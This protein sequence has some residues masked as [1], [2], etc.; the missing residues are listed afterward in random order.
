MPEIKNNFLQGKMNQDLDER[1]IPN[2]QYREAMNVEVST[3]E[4]AGAGT[5]QN[6]LGNT[7]ASG[8][9]AMF[10]SCVCVG[11][12]ADEK[13][14]KLYWFVHC[15]DRDA[16]IEYDEI[17]DKSQ[18]ILCDL[19]SDE[20]PL[21]QPFLKFGSSKITGI[22]IID[23]FLFWTDGNSEP[24]K[25]NIK[26]AKARQKLLGDGQTISHH[27][28]YWTNTDGYAMPD[29]PYVREE[30]LTII[31]KKPLVAPKVKI[32]FSSTLKTSS[33]RIFERSFIRFCVR[34]KYADGEYSAYSP[35]TQVVYNPI[36]KSGLNNFNY[37]S[38]EESYNTSMIN[39]IESIDLYGF[40]DS[41]VN[42]DVVQVDVLAKIE[43]SPNVYSIK[44]IKR[45]DAE[46]EDGGELFQEFIGTA[47]SSYGGSL[48]KGKF[49]VKSESIHA[50]VPNNQNLRPW[51][52]VPRKALAQEVTGNRVVYGNYT[53][54]YSLKDVLNSDIN[55]G[56]AAKAEQR[57][58]SFEFTD[59]PTINRGKRS[60]KSQRSYTLGVVY[61]DVYGRETPVLTSDNA[62]V[63][64]PWY[65]SS[66]SSAL[67]LA[68]VPTMLS[69]EVSSNHPFWADSY[70]FYVKETSGEYY[71][72][73]M[74][75][76]YLPGS[77]DLWDN[78]DR[79][80]WIAFSSSDRNKVSE[81]TYL[82]IKKVLNPANYDQVTV[83]NKYKVLDIANEAPDAIKFDY[84]NLGKVSNN[85][86]ELDGTG[87]DEDDDNPVS[88]FPNQ[89][90][91]ID[92]E[93]DKI[94]ISKTD[95]NNISGSPF[96][97][98]VG[99]EDVVVEPDDIYISWKGLVSDELRN[100]TRYKVISISLSSETYDIKLATKISSIDAEI[101]DAA[102]A[103]A[104][105]SSL[106]FRVE[107]KAE[108]DGE[109]F[110]GKFFVK[111]QQDA[112]TSLN[113]AIG[114]NGDEDD[115]Q[116][117]GTAEVY[118]A[119]A[120][121]TYYFAN[122]SAPSYHDS[123]IL[124][125]TSD[126]IVPTDNPADVHG[127]DNI[128]LTVDDWDAL[129]TQDGTGVG[130]FFIDRTSF[131]SSAFDSTGLARESGQPFG[132]AEGQSSSTFHSSV[133]SKE[134]VWDPTQDA[135]ARV[136]G[137]FMDGSIADFASVFSSTAIG[138]FA[139]VDGNAEDLVNTDGAI[140]GGGPLE[141]FN[142]LLPLQF[143]YIINNIE[144][145][146]VGSIEQLS[147][148]FGAEGIED[149][150]DLF[151]PE[152][153]TEK[154]LDNVQKCY[155][156][157]TTYKGIEPN[158]LW[159]R[160]A[161]D[162]DGN[163][164]TGLEGIVESGS[165][166]TAGRYRWKDNPYVI[167][168]F[169]NVYEENG[170]Y[171]MYLSFL[172]PG[173]D[174]HDGSGLEAALQDN[175]ELNG[176]NGIGKY[177]Q[178]IW[179]GGVFS[180]STR[181][182]YDAKYEEVLNGI[183]PSDLDYSESTL[184]Q[185][186][187]SSV[188][189]QTNDYSNE[190]YT[191]VA[192]ETKLKHSRIFPTEFGEPVELSKFLTSN[193]SSQRRRKMHV[194]FEGNYNELNEPN[195]EPP[196]A[197]NAGDGVIGY[198]DN[199]ASRHYN[200]WNPAFGHPNET[201]INTFLFYLNQPNAQFRFANDTSE[202]V[203]TINSVT[204]K[205]LYNHTPWRRRFVLSKDAPEW[206]PA[207]D[208]VE[209][210]VIEW[211]NTCGTG[212]VPS[213][214]DGTASTLAER[215]IN[216]GK[217]SNRRLVYI[218]ELD[219]NPLTNLD[220]N[221]LN[222]IDADSPT[223]IEF[224]SANGAQ[225]LNT[226]LATFPA[227]METESKPSADLELYYEASDSIP[228]SINTKKQGE[229]FAPIGC[230]VEFPNM[231]FAST[232]NSSV[233]LA[234][235]SNEGEF[236]VRV[237]DEDV[238]GFNWFNPTIPTEM[239][240]YSGQEVRFIR[241]DGSYTTGIISLDYHSSL[242][243]DEFGTLN[244]DGVAFS[245]IE[246]DAYPNGI[247]N[248]FRI[249]ELPG[250]VGL[251]WYNCFTFEDGVESNR[252]R[253]D[254]NEMQITNGAKASTVIE[255]PYTEEHRKN[256]LIYSGIYNSNSGVNNLNQFIAAEKITK[257][258]NPT[259]GSIQ[260][261]YSR[262]TDLVALCED[263]IIKI[264]ANKD[265]LF[266]ADGTPQLVAT[267]NVLGQAVPFVGDY[268]ISKNPESFAS[269]SYRAYF[270]D[271]QR[272]AV[273][274]LS[275]DG[276][277]PISDAG[278]HDWF[279]DKFHEGQ[280]SFIGSYDN[281]KRQYNLTVSEKYFGNLISNG[282][283]DSGSSL[284]EYFVNQNIVENPSFAGGITEVFP[285]FQN[286]IYGIA[287]LEDPIIDNMFFNTPVVIRYHDEIPA[288]S[289]FEGGTITTPPSN[290]AVAEFVTPEVLPL[291]AQAVNMLDGSYGTFL[292]FEFLEQ[293]LD[294]IEAYGSANY[295]NN[296]YDTLTTNPISS[297]GSFKLSRTIAGNH[298]TTPNDWEDA[299]AAIG[300]PNYATNILTP[301]TNQY[302]GALGRAN[303]WIDMGGA[304]TVFGPDSSE[305]TANDGIM[306]SNI[307]FGD[308]TI[309]GYL[310][311][312][313]IASAFGL[314]EPDP[315]GE[316]EAAATISPSSGSYFNPPN[317]LLNY[318]TLPYSVEGNPT[319]R[320]SEN[321]LYWHFPDYI[322]DGDQ[323]TLYN[324][325][326]A[327]GT[328]PRYD[329]SD[330]TNFTI[331]SGE[332]IEVEFTA[333]RYGD[334]VF[335]PVEGS[336]GALEY[337]YDNCYKF[338][339]QLVGDGEVVDTDYIDGEDGSA[340]WNTHSALPTIAEDPTLDITHFVPLL[341]EQ[342][343]GSWTEG[344]LSS[345]KGPYNIGWADD[346]TVIFDE[347]PPD[348]EVT[349]K[350]RFKFI[351]PI[352]DTFASFE[353]GSAHKIF[354]K[355]EVRIGVTATENDSVEY[356]TL[357][358]LGGDDNI[359]RQGACIKSAYVRKTKK[360]QT[361]G[362]LSFLGSEMDDIENPP[363]PASTIPAW[364]EVIYPTAPYTGFP[365]PTDWNLSVNVSSNDVIEEYGEENPP[366]V[367]DYNYV[368]AIGET[369][370]GSY[371]NGG[372]NGVTP[373][374]AETGSLFG[375]V[376]AASVYDS[377]T[378]PQGYREVE[379]NINS[380]LVIQPS[381]GTSIKQFNKL[382]PGRW[383]MIDIYY[384]QGVDDALEDVIG[385]TAAFVLGSIDPKGH[386]YDGAITY[387][388]FKKTRNY[389]Y[390]YGVN[391]EIPATFDGSSTMNT[392]LAEI[393][394][395][396]NYGNYA[397]AE[398]YRIIFK[399]Y[400]NDLHLHTSAITTTAEI[401]AILAFDITQDVDNNGTEPYSWTP[402]R[403]IDGAL[404]EMP[405]SLLHP[406][407][408]LSGFVDN[409]TDVQEHK[410]TPQVFYRNGGI[411]WIAKDALVGWSDTDTNL[412][413]VTSTSNYRIEFAVGIEPYVGYNSI[414]YIDDD[415]NIHFHEGTYDPGS[416]EI[417][418]ALLAA[419]HPGKIYGSLSCKVI[420]GDGVGVNITN[421]KAP[422]LYR[423]VFNP[424]DPSDASIEAQPSFETL[425][426]YDSNI[427]VDILDDSIPST[428]PQIL[429]HS[430]EDGFVGRVSSVLLSDITPSFT[431]GSLEG[432]SIDFG[433]DTYGESD[434]LII[435]DNTAQALG[436][437]EIP[438]GATDGGSALSVYQTLDTSQ[439]DVGQSYQ[440]NF[441]HNFEGN[442]GVSFYFILGDTNNSVMMYGQTA[443][444]SGSYSN[445]FQIGSSENIIGDIPEDVIYNSLVFQP[446]SSDGSIVNG[447]IDDIVLQ[448]VNSPSGNDRTTIS[449][450]ESVNGWVSFKSFL[451]EN[452]LSLSKQYYTMKGGELYKHYT[453][454]ARN[455]FYGNFS[456]ST[457]KLV[458]NTGPSTVKS[459][460]T[461]AFEGTTAEVLQYF[462]E[463]DITFDNQE[464]KDGWSVSNITTDLQEGYV[465]EFIKKEGKWFNYIRSKQLQISGDALLST[466]SDFGE[467][468]FQ[469]IGYGAMIVTQTIA[470]SDS[471]DG[472]VAEGGAAAAAA[473]E[474]GSSY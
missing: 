277:T 123:G 469:G 454:E 402:V 50:I 8:D 376:S 184:P 217:K 182:T 93:V 298:L 130:F 403:V 97:G 103:S 317:S 54:G 164:V 131:A 136:S 292:G 419:D 434:A 61:A 386:F 200:Q 278:M 129:L 435:W 29:D 242:Y 299:G 176:N 355:L 82:I 66:V 342:L 388:K 455:T 313:M 202:T 289:I 282:T 368:N 60:L 59:L 275:M 407:H 213:G 225:V 91:R 255:E 438:Y 102:A 139:Y 462:D 95:W 199:Y 257:D 397:G 293:N 226:E 341:G 424:S 265:A 113:G 270:T 53:Q 422:G 258:L 323:Q 331:F 189:D 367:V 64:L 414:N 308:G 332:E 192:E 366:T 74:L 201:E 297:F 133:K 392:V 146:D 420:L 181:G 180:N 465:P 416:T 81:D 337:R 404:S 188:Q 76:S 193:P 263:R 21:V 473:V 132:V 208:S 352:N 296:H 48:S 84:Y 285:S 235:W 360:L 210:A 20:D 153:W 345:M 222:N 125:T 450:S 167:D 466:D 439:M 111:I 253:D 196:S 9:I 218:L 220:F 261:L 245:T 215:I 410:I 149:F 161:A 463:R 432:W 1:L 471:D 249:N 315:L 227:I 160:N 56:V 170:K 268:G 101:A 203:Y 4:E 219:Q 371:L 141:N 7:L 377:L 224:I 287:G 191:A 72:L 241:E 380:S 300:G 304:A 173:E 458:L 260:K 135:R 89:E 236:D 195:P 365:Q 321:V 413:S 271:Q 326:Q 372:S 266:N 83:E 405:N 32:N 267:E 423:V 449:F 427:S 387:P 470:D 254:F 41:N 36:Y 179:G 351:D 14:N 221:P 117:G 194:E 291:G 357:G 44:S 122:D 62:G 391:D 124:G 137:N 143:Y 409:N 105:N 17:L 80:I 127:G 237:K 429:F 246:T 330:T 390:A 305:T 121:S 119:A 114:Q 71:N 190:K 333:I 348:V 230:R 175:A 15:D 34:Y 145:D 460:N 63:K 340:Y 55:V 363:L 169:D 389:Q 166:H 472:V 437:N 431:G 375:H 134:F 373:Y 441:N 79:H 320:V 109:D 244:P 183:S 126:G 171:Y 284:E 379:E 453:N 6:I 107:R 106:I 3:S 152:T 46:W 115:L 319:N 206:I 73:V 86:G 421:I 350:A 252:V 43:N 415:G 118:I 209:E 154:H 349:H 35:F 11:S 468:N 467:L 100:S 440:L 232:P 165:P 385:H 325:V 273:L 142:A 96:A 47:E 259:Y 396:E 147:D 128:S 354:N 459:F 68:S 39:G 418:T 187:P 85:S 18:T 99:G 400:Q 279:R 248:K 148:A 2:G 157:T 240:D 204:K 24:K 88:I 38:T 30:H 303:I 239:L 57:Y 27:S 399:A 344:G 233:R 347:F 52:N 324:N 362:I 451:P 444:G 92:Q 381:S 185:L 280:F 178:G 336:G 65:D 120:Q 159:W 274:R 212:V 16:I 353:L 310:F 207:E 328:F 238:S 443:T 364:A 112:E 186:S 23:N 12:I 384:K 90:F 40:I 33:D 294:I 428:E 163:Q 369:I 110:S 216:F 269:E 314:D 329:F 31:K 177:M 401:D 234:G 243:L 406:P 464:G 370:Y 411:S 335:F 75:R 339:I 138:D 104:L 49:K 374:E 37:F 290:P 26:H 272:G 156:W 378:L 445:T 383:Y 306:F 474:G 158:S 312:V 461:I 318:I 5:I 359:F 398:C 302:A 250:K 10:D 446:Y 286:E 69:A 162:N 343:T 247:R 456:P 393:Y 382:T 214:N 19:I 22:N 144:T 358:S 155:G 198:D 77:Y 307:Y 70:K 322:Y 295:F 13:N 98:G 430:E 447:S 256:G 408:I 283:F 108:K 174:L 452:G 264:L 356:L 338:F 42:E 394:D 231:P 327:D 223:N 436:F 205:R 150:A 334:Y 197:L 28:R 251:G 426:G 316:Y 87:G 346:S 116:D 442:T 311:A 395:N 228:I 168:A 425:E 412:P 301:D 151:S 140:V 172:A 78:I 25:V 276:L 211:A 58:E 45:T 417:G 309:S 94:N 288:E 361:P 51:D 262:S 67:P 457:V 433:D 448:Q 281:Y 229:I